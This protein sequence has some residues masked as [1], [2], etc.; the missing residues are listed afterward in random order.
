MMRRSSGRR[1]AV[2][3]WEG[4]RR[5]KKKKGEENVERKEEELLPESVERVQSHLW[6]RRSAIARGEKEVESEGSVFFPSHYLSV[7][8]PYT[9]RFVLM[10]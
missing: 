5:K 6:R 1:R 2:R 9:V 8:S 7:Y 4:M 3:P 10:Y